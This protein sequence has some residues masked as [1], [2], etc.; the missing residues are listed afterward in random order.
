MLWSS[1]PAAPLLAFTSLYACHTIRLVTGHAFESSIF[2]SLFVS[3][4]D[5]IL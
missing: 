4:L 5:K 1:T 3:Y 2:V